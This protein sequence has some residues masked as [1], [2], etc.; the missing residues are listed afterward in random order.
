MKGG[1]PVVSV[2]RLMLPLVDTEKMMVRGVS[3]SRRMRMRL[4]PHRSV[5]SFTLVVK[6]LVIMLA[7]SVAC[8]HR[9]ISRLRLSVRICA[10]SVHDGHAESVYF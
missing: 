3:L 4:Q 10:R 1:L 2:F 6:L 8:S 7:A 5:S 9:L